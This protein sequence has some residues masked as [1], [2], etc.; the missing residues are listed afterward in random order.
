MFVLTKSILQTNT[1][2]IRNTFK[3]VAL[4]GLKYI[5]LIRNLDELNLPR[6][7]KK[8]LTTT[9]TKDIKQTTR[10]ISCF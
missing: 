1:L 3:K 10:K 9:L 4:N 2:K 5:N 8:C 7:K 6:N